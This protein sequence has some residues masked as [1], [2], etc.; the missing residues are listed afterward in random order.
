MSNKASWR[1]YIAPSLIVG[2]PVGVIV[3]SAVS[4]AFR[5]GIPEGRVHHGMLV[6]PPI[7]LATVLADETDAEHLDPRRP[8]WRLAVVQREC[9]DMCQQ[10]VSDAENMKLS[11][12]RETGELRLL[13]LVAP[14]GEG[15]AETDDE[16]WQVARLSPKGAATLSEVCGELDGCMAMVSQQHDIAFVYPTSDSSPRLILEDILKILRNTPDTSR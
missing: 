7:A 15:S 12:G 4:F 3:L 16:G 8:R 9:A 5:W 2:M 13:R 1:K 10:R 14:M 11:V 6:S